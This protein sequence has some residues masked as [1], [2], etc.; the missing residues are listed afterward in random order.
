[1]TAFTFIGQTIDCP[2]CASSDLARVG[3][4]DRHGNPLTTD[5]CRRCGHVFTN[6]QPTE[7]D[8]DQFYADRYRS[9]YKG[10]TT[11]KRK[12][13]YRAGLRALER[14]D[15]LRPFLKAGNRILDIGAGGGEFTY[16][17][18]KA[19]Y[20]T[21]GI[22]PN[23]GYA[24]FSKAEYGIDVQIGTVSD[25]SQNKSKWNVITL[26]HVLEHLT[27]PV[28]VLR[29]LATHLDENGVIVIEVPNVEARYH[30]PQRRF[31]FA[32]LH[33]FSDEGLR[34]AASLAG[35]E[36]CD[37]LLQPNTGHIN[38]VFRNTSNAAL[39]PD[40]AVAHRIEHHLKTDT[41]LRDLFTARPYRRLWAN[42]KRPLREKAALTHLNASDK[43]KDILDH[44]YGPE[45]D[46]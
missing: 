16:L 33:T 8:L 11:P 23:R 21:Q 24:E 19:G 46:R 45:L 18:T 10:V 4:R 38:S 37:S 9:S 2:I 35:L 15:R 12:H 34:L 29:D 40:N 1:M 20:V 30:G 17:M 28:A 41:P 27:D 25:I 26:H 43:A 7:A 39:T 6:P 42:L 5:M 44:V 22:E 13:V 32:H 14:L 3:S 31:H 36:R